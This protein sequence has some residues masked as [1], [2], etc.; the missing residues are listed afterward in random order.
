MSP[1]DVDRIA[2]DDE[3][4]RHLLFIRWVLG[5]PLD[6]ALRMATLARINEFSHL[7]VEAMHDVAA[8]WH[9][10]AAATAS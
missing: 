2:G 4:M 6:D 8:H 3:F 9:E 10:P 1:E 7:T 5:E